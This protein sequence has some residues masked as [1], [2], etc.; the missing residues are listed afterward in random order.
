MLLEHGALVD[1]PT[2]DGMTPLMVASSFDRPDF[3][4]LLL[5]HGA[6]VN[7]A[8][9]G[10]RYSGMTALHFAC[11]CDLK[12]MACLL[13]VRG[14]NVDLRGNFGRTPLMDCM[15]KGNLRTAK[16]LVEHAADVNIKDDENYTALMIACISGP[17]ESVQLL[18]DSGRCDLTA[19]GG[20]DDE[21]LWTISVYGLE[22]NDKKTTRADSVAVLQLLHDTEAFNVDEQSVLDNSTA[23][24]RAVMEDDL[25]IAGM[26]LDWGADI[27]IKG[28]SMRNTTALQLCLNLTPRNEA[29]F[30]LLFK[31]HAARVQRPLRK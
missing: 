31:E 1:L 17:A 20:P 18:L 30:G 19:R 13:L 24:H 7:T 25:E 27:N 8:V 23:L 5:D 9:S 6:R 2:V 12:H 22:R 16:L 10:G 15:M 21:N 4:T 28:S 3:A 11:G 29:M 14:A 26:L